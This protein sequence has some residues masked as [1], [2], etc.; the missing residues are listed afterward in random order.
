M[1]G[2]PSDDSA[3]RRLRQVFF[4]EMFFQDCSRLK[5]CCKFLE[6]VNATL[7]YTSFKYFPK[8]EGAM[9]TISL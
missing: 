5:S 9:V 8:N 4:G 2:N 1:T 7:S 3:A 6:A